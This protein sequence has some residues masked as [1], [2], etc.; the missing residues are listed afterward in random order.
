M[1]ESTT[2][3]YPC[4]MP[5]VMKSRKSEMPMMMS[6]LRMGMLLTNCIAWRA[7]RWRRLWMPMAVRVP[8]R[9][10]TVAV[11][12]AMVTVLASAA[13]SEWWVPSAKRFL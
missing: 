10:D 6:P 9:V 3:V 4:G 1:W 2:V 13:V 8:K 7:P 12:R 11:M 5:N